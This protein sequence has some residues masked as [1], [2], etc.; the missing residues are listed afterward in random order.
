M[1]SDIMSVRELAE[2]RRAELVA[3]VASFEQLNMVCPLRYIAAV[4]CCFCHVP[5][6]DWRAGGVLML[7]MTCVW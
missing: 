1:H 5:C 4:C 6:R 3:S 2:L 7:T